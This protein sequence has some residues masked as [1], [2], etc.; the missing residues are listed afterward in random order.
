MPGSG[1]EAVPLAM[2]LE[3]RGRLAALNGDHEGALRLLEACGDLLAPQGEHQPFS[4]W[5]LRAAL[6]LQR[7]DRLQVAA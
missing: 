5:R 4:Q 6:C 3:A 1:E 7:L 2:V